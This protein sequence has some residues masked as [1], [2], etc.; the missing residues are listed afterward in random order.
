MTEPDDPKHK[1]YNPLQWDAV[2]V[3]TVALLACVA[4][5]VTV[6]VI[7]LVSYA[8]NQRRIQECLQVQ[9]AAQQE[10]TRIARA[11]AKDDR[12][13]QREL[14]LAQTDPESGRAAVERYLARLDET[15]RTRTANPPP[16][17][18]CL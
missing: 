18:S 9:V 11:L 14:L 3:I 2:R 5:A 7:Y 4:L 12:Q 6:L 10:Y 13:A 8:A 1:V 16:A 15:D 17:T